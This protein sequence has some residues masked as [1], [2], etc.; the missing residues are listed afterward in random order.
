MALINAWLR[1]LL[2]L[3][4]FVGTGLAAADAGYAY[5]QA[6]VK[7][8]KV[9]ASLAQKAYDNAMSRIAKQPKGYPCTP[10]NI[11]IRKEW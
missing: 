1:L 6:D 10:Q 2:A 3:S 7:S 4:L 8:G 5:S 9:L 11:K